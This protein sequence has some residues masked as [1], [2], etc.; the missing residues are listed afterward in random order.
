MPGWD[1]EKWIVHWG[2]AYATLGLISSVLA[3]CSTA[4]TFHNEVVA[5]PLVAAKHVLAW[6]S[7]ACMFAITCMFA[8]LCHADRHSNEVVPDIKND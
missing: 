5:P 3:I 8:I 2:A 6:L 1:V 7:L 4:S